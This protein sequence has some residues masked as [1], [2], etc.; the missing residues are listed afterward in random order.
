MKKLV[1]MLGFLMM[2]WGVGFADVKSTIITHDK[3][4][5]GNIRVWTSFEVDGVEIES[6]YPKING[7]Y[8]YCTRYN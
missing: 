7:H 4:T 3:D 2:M 1:L 5:N 6:N 8:V